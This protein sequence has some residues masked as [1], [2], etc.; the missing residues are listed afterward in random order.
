[1][2][3]VL[4]AEREA[5]RAIQVC[6]N[7]ARQIID[8]AQSRVQDLYARTDQRITNMEMRHDHRLDRLIK[9]IAKEGD[10]ELRNDAGR[11]YDEKKLQS[12]IRELAAELCG[13]SPESGK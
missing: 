6:E 11:Q 8:A 13:T 7:E 4:Q 10:A 5:E 12:V 2:E 3:K 9:N 1:M